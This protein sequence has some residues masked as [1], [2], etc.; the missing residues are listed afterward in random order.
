MPRPTTPSTA[1]G[2]PTRR[3]S[4]PTT[5]RTRCTSIPALGTAFTTIRRR[6]TTRPRPRSPGTARSPSSRR[7]W[8][9]D[10]CAPSGGVFGVPHLL[11]LPPVQHVTRPVG[12]GIH[13]A[14]ATRNL[15]RQLDHVA[16]GITEV[17]RADEF[18]VRDAAH[19]AALR[20]A[21]GKHVVERL[22]RDFERD[23]QV[24][25]VLLLELEWHLGRLEEGEAGALVALEDA[26]QHADTRLAAGHGRVDL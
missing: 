6:A 20:L 7:T 4:R 22:G 11:G 18:V 10:D 13:I 5:S 15:G 19:L 9:P 8:S 17:D 26:V 1:C 23:M 16:V 21:L 2:R 14:L 25:V 3:R 24:E 12:R